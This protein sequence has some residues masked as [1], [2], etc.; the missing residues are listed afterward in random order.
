M[1]NQPKILEYR[2]RDY[3]AALIETLFLSQE[4]RTKIEKQIP[5]CEG[6][7]DIADYRARQRYEQY[8]INKKT[9]AQ[10]RLTSQDYKI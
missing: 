1:T 7:A 9:E 8:R 2:R 3:V 6:L 5:A 10:N 4:E